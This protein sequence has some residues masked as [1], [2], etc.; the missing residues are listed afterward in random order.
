MNILKW[1]YPELPSQ[2]LHGTN[3]MPQAV[4]LYHKHV[5]R[6][7]R[8]TFVSWG[9][10]L[11]LLTHNLFW[12]WY[13]PNKVVS[14]SMIILVVFTGIVMKLERA[15][16]LDLKWWHGRINHERKRAKLEL[17]ILKPTAW[18]RRLILT[19]GE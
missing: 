7:Q 3:D 19:E 16:W 10:L 4:A 8:M 5:Q 12:V 17:T 13:S 11:L 9:L 14:I 6:A 18:Q 15:V 1:L 2:T